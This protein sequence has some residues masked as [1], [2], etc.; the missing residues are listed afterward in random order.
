MCIITGRK[1]VNL[2]ILKLWNFLILLKMVK[3]TRILYRKNTKTIYQI[4]NY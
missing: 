4:L 1:S 3:S 2:V